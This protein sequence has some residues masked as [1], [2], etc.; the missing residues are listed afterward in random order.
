MLFA[1]LSVHADGSPAGRLT[2]AKF[3]YRQ[4]PDSPTTE[5]AILHTLRDDLYVILGS[6][7]EDGSVATFRLHLNALVAFIWIGLLLMLFGTGISLFPELERA[8]F[9]A[10]TYVRPGATEK[11]AREEGSAR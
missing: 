1:D 6:L 8:R 3:T 2:P 10:W 11:P 4:Q 9:G 7:G 5:V